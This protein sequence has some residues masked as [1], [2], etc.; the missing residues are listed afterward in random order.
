M[1]DAHLE[2]GEHILVISSSDLIPS[3]YRSHQNR[4][5]VSDWVPFIAYSRLEPFSSALKNRYEAYQRALKL[6]EQHEGGLALF[7][8]GYKT[9]GFQV[10]AQGGVRYREWAPNAVSAR[11]IGDFS[12]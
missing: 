4:S 3:R 6:I 8:E 12:E 9:M 7:S 5:M 2:D 10:D 11:L 1:S